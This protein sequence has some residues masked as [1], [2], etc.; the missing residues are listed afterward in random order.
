M[1]NIREAFRGKASFFIIK[2]ESD[3]HKVYFLTGITIQI[4]IDKIEKK[5]E[6][7]RSK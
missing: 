1:K 4:V 6:Q 5:R 3:C 2:N 7:N